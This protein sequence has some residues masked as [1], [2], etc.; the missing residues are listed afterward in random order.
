MK[1]AVERSGGWWPFPRHE[2]EMGR[3]NARRA[4]KW[5]NLLTVFEIFLLA[6]TPSPENSNLRDRPVS[7]FPRT[8]PSLWSWLAD[9]TNASLCAHLHLQLV[10]ANKH[11]N[12]RHVGF[13]FVKLYGF[14]YLTIKLSQNV[15]ISKSGNFWKIPMPVKLATKQRQTQE[16][17]PGNWER[18]RAWSI[19]KCLLPI[20]Y[21]KQQTGTFRFIEIENEQL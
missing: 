21:M 5:K 17:R 13:V 16:T 4:D 15:N 3:V 18:R 10:V 12:Q 6:K 11:A 20:Q 8:N 1:G 2:G 14:F 19:V 7:L 9:N